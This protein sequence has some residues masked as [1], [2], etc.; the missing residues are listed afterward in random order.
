[1][2]NK[3]VHGRHS[4]RLGRF[5]RSADAV[6]RVFFLPKE[7]L[8]TSR[9]AA[10][11]LGVVF[12]H[13][14]CCLS[15]M[16]SGGDAVG[17]KMG[18]D[19]LT[20]IA[21]FAIEGAASI[22]HSKA[23]ACICETSDMHLDFT[24]NGI[25]RVQEI[26]EVLGGERRGALPVMMLD[27][28]VGEHE[29]TRKGDRRVGGGV[30]L[31]GEVK[32]LSGIMSITCATPD[33]LAGIAGSLVNLGTGLASKRG[34]IMQKSMSVPQVH[35]DKCYKCKRCLRVCPVGALHMTAHAVR[36]DAKK[37][38]RCG[39]CVEAAHYGGITFD[40]NASPA[41]Y[42]KELASY[43]SS[44]SAV[45]EGRIICVNL[46]Y[47]KEGRERKKRFKGAFVSR[48]PV[49]VDAAALD[50]CETYGVLGKDGL[51]N[52]RSLI[53]K[54]DEMDAGS[55]RYRLITVAY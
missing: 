10:R 13:R 34:K 18:R 51:K 55:A 22:R 14:D 31:A 45:L 52:A 20:H 11:S 40:W 32:N 53:A 37:C 6:P 23:Q 17:I 49:A 16:F 44:L 54:A 19:H 47:A 1:M 41:H 46:I 30:Y 50:A 29:L 43:C 33:A 25:G 2:S 12:A 42:Q 5:G 15:R 38:I 8:K 35:A 48:D 21:P 36:I 7:M 27:G 26:G 4:R 9:Q 28:I 3:P 39:R 24:D